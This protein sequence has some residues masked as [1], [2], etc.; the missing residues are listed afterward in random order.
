MLL[1]I[2][3]TTRN[4]VFGFLVIAKLGCEKQKNGHLVINI[5]KLMSHEGIEEFLAELGQMPFLP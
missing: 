5:S 3:E 2:I 4:V 1:I